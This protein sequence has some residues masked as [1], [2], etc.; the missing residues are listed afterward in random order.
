VHVAGE[1]D[2]RTLR[3]SV[4][5][6]GC[7][8]NPA[9]APDANAGHFGLEGIRERIKRMNGTFELKSAPGNGC[10]AVITI[11]SCRSNER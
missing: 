10:I 4:A 2:A 11:L 8:F 6:N 7:G 5:D 3:F 9:T 1:V